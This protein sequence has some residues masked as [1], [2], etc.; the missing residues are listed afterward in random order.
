MY[1]YIYFVTFQKMIIYVCPVFTDKRSLTSWQNNY[2]YTPRN[3][4]AKAWIKDCRV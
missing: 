1:A 3:L 4:A 2:N